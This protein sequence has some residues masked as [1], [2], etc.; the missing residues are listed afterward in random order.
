MAL[1]DA[2][3]SAGLRL[4]GRKP[5][6]F[7]GSPEVFEMEACDLVNEVAQ[8]IAKYQDWQ[9]LIRLAEL[10]GNG[11]I[12]VFDLPGDY[13]RQMQS[14]VIQDGSTWAWGYQRFTDLNAFLFAQ[15]RGFNGSPGGW[16]IY[17][18]K[19]RFTPAPTGTAMY[20][21]V[22]RNWAKSANGE[23]KSSFTADNDEYLLP[24]RLLTLGLV[25]RWRENKRLD[26]SGDQEA[27]VK[28]LDEYAAKDK[29]SRVYRSSSR[30]SFRGTHLAWPYELGA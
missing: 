3:Q 17:G 29:G 4:I 5:G 21:Y 27:F 8:D 14:A 25:W 18:D 15:A 2:L 16:T 6:T 20:P 1:L 10:S 9:A 11:V 13:D 7:F 28:A 12:E 22:T 24:D 30:R 19:V 26:A 23:A